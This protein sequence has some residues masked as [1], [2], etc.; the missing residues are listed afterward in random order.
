L[1]VLYAQSVKT[2]P[3]PIQKFSANLAEDPEAQRRV[4]D[5][6]KTLVGPMM[7][8][9]NRGAAHEAG[10]TPDVAGRAMATTYPAVAQALGKE[11]AEQTEAGFSSRL[12]GLFA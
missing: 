11:N 1:K 8:A 3:E 12:K 6:C 9:L 4:V 10:T 2:L 7:E 5:E